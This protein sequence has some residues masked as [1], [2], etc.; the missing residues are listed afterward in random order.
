[1]LEY[2]FFSYIR[3][4]CV[5]P[6]VYLLGSLVFCVMFCRSLFVLLS[7]FFWPLCCLSFF[8]LHNLITHLVFSNSS[9]IIW[10]LNG[11]WWRPLQKHVPLNRLQIY[12]FYFIYCTVYINVLVSGLQKQ[13][14]CNE[15]TYIYWNRSRRVIVD[16][17][18][19]RKQ[20]LKQKRT[21]SK[22]QL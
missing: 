1:M 4:F 14:P 12:V 19:K 9:Y 5:D 17:P 21:A 8:E 2:H 18:I 22:A 15:M 10:L 11:T 6:L 3:L 16:N 13:E 7:F 20:K